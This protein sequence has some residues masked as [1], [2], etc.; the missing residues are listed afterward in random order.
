MVKEQIR[1]TQNGAAEGVRTDLFGK[2]YAY[3]RSEAAEAAGVFPFFIPL[4]SQ[5]GTTAMVDG[6]SVL[7]FGSNNY[8]GLTEDQRVR[9]AAIESIEKYGTGC[10]GSRLLNG[11]LD[12]H[13][14]MERRLASFLG[15]DDAAVFTTGFQTNLGVISALVGRHEYAIIDEYTHASIRDGCRLAYG[16]TLKFRHNDMAD[17]ERALKSIPDGRAALIVVDGVYSMEGDLANLPEIV[18]LKRR[19]GARLLVDDAHAIG[20]MGENGRGTAEHFGVE[21]EVDLITGTFSKSLASVGGFCVG[22]AKIIRYVQHIARSF[23]FAASASPPAV[24][25]A[26]KALDI[27]ETEPAL[28]RRLWDNAERMRSGLRRLGFDT[29]HSQTPIIPMV[30]GPEMAMGLFWYGLFNSGVYTNAVLAPAVPQDG[31]LIRTSC[32]AAHTTEQIDEALAIIE[33]VGRE[34]SL[35]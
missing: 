27:V 18:E 10:T 3:N 11:T 33:R 14:E 26:M 6:R 2:C 24:G 19:Y 35:I 17:L 29:G 9:A 4:S 1:S 12:L 16:N 32:T 31:A 34:Q 22:D 13:K 23:M 20:V 5:I 8:L 7:M 28:R 25:A 30:I 15:R 21:N